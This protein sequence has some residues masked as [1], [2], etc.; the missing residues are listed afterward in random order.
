[1][2]NS[3]I[4]VSLLACMACYC[5][6][7]ECYVCNSAFHKDCTQ[8]YADRKYLVNC[9]LDTKQP[10]MPSKPTED[11]SSHHQRTKRDTAPGSLKD[12]TIGS[13]IYPSNFTMCRK[14]VITIPDQLNGNI[15][16]KSGQTRV[17]RSCGWE[18]DPSLSQST[19]GSVCRYGTG[20]GII[21]YMCACKENGCNAAGNLNVSKTFVLLTLITS[22]FVMSVK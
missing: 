16:L 1:M 10:L 21:N 4:I 17:F 13:P 2:K 20:E 7:L 12:V 3:V 9:T 15:P 11:V 18:Q 19:T 6:A 22:L 14:L 5:S 8:S